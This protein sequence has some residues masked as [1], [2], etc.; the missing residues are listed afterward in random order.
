[1]TTAATTRE[2]ERL[3][4]TEMVATCPECQDIIRVAIAPIDDLRDNGDWAIADLVRGTP[5]ASTRCQRA[6][7]AAASKLRQLYH[8][9]GE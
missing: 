5:L 8:L 3:V 9:M 1:M 4:L 6:Q 7:A 2:L